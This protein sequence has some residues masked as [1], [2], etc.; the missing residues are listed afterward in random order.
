MKRA[1]FVLIAVICS[2]P[3]HA[4]KPSLKETLDWMHS[5]FP[6]TESMTA[7]RAKQTREL[8][9][10][11]GKDGA[12]PSCTITMIDRWR[13]DEGKSVVR[14]TTIDLSLI[15]PGSVKS[16]QED[17]VDKGTGVLTFVT[18]NDKKVIVE[19][20]EVDGK[21]DNKPLE[22]N[23]QFVSF[24]GTEYSERFAKAFTN[25]TVASGAISPGPPGPMKSR[26]DSTVSPRRWVSLLAAA[27]RVN[28]SGPGRRPGHS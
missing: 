20:T 12:P 9:Y 25:A 5:A 27:S 8:N 22:T 6:D 28:I 2:T 19:K 13:T 1:T 16:Y 14:Y 3:L 7:F 23:R 21:P 10:V 15:D 18:S 11:D 4:Q 24:I 26:I 17:L